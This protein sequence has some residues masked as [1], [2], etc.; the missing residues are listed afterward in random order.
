MEL[1]ERAT[2]TLRM[3]KNLLFKIDTFAASRKLT[4]TQAILE[5]IENREIIILPE[6]CEILKQLILL[7]NNLEKEDLFKQKAVEKVC[8]ELWQLLNLTT[9][10]TQS[11]QIKGI[12]SK[13]L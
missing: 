9:A 6:G 10:K 5:I 8:D 4:R 11:I 2:V 1:S 3:N 13:G 12:D 7:N